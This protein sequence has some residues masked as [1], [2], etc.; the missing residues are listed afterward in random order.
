MMRGIAI[1]AAALAALAG[2]AD[3]DGRPTPRAPEPL[4]PGE[5]LNDPT[6]VRTPTSAELAALYPEP[7]R[8]ARRGDAVSVDCVISQA[9]TLDHCKIDDE[10]APERGFGLATMEA[11]KLFQT[12]PASRDGRPVGGLHIALRMQWTPPSAGVAEAPFQAVVLSIPSGPTAPLVIWHPDWM[13]QPTGDEIADLY[14]DAARA[15]GIQ[16]AAIIQCQVARSGGLTDC[17]SL[18]EA[19]LGEGFGEATVKV[20]RHFV[21]RPTFDGK[22]VEGGIVLIPM[23]WRLG[24]R[25]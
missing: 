8:R 11:L 15:R 7:A 20:A 21:V 16:G 13:S 25:G 2:R 12:S 6:W 5:Y 24:P 19:P 22:S 1:M 23:R 4:P 9:G 14:P 10:Y 3:A 18:Q 17:V